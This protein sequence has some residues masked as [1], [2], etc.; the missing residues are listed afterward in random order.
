MFINNPNYF[1]LNVLNKNLSLEEYC[2]TIYTNKIQ[3]D[4]ILLYKNLVLD[5]TQDIKDLIQYI[6]FCSL[7][8]NI[9]YQVKK[10]C[11]NICETLE[12]KYSLYGELVFSNSNFNFEKDFLPLHF[13]NNKNINE[14][15]NSLIEIDKNGIYNRKK[16][17]K[18]QIKEI[19]FNKATI[20]KKSHMNEFIDEFE[21]WSNMNEIINPYY[22]E[23]F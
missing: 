4:I 18:H 2:K 22:E 6:Q 21:I 19:F 8:E 23:Y 16:L 17:L 11:N 15:S 14:F 20:H 10:I 7:N 13:K 12:I 5:I 1:I 3:S 9:F